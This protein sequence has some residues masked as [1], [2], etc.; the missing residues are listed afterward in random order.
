MVFTIYSNCF[1]ITFWP[2]WLAIPVSIGTRS[3][4]GRVCFAIDC[5]RGRIDCAIGRRF[6][7]RPITKLFTCFSLLVIG[8]TSN[9][10][11]GNISC[12]GNTPAPFN[13]SIL[14]LIES[15][16]VLKSRPSK[17]CIFQP[18]V[19][20][21]CT[22]YFRQA[23]CASNARKCMNAGWLAVIATLAQNCLANHIYV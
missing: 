19:C 11:Q 10:T 14:D 17:V 7:S 22:H 8:V 16:R 1:I 5:P 20:G 12:S 2:H 3:F 23:K 9:I 4:Q 6:F 21:C 18:A 15:F 13:V